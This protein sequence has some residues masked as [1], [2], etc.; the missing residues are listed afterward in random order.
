MQHAERIK[1]TEPKL[2]CI[3]H[4]WFVRKIVG[5]PGFK[6]KGSIIYVLLHVQL[7]EME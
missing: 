3:T 6:T 5:Y 4:F 2:N 7:N 1:S